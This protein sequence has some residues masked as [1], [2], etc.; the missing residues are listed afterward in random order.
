[1]AFETKVVTIAEI[2]AVAN[3]S[4]QYRRA[5]AIG[6]TRARVRE[7]VAWKR[8][9]GMRRRRTNESREEDCKWETLRPRYER[10]TQ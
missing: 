7:F 5:D 3:R 9:G 2:G 1:M 4:I 10:L 6:V 8:R